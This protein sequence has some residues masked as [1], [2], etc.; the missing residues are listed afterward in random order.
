MNKLKFLPF[1][2]VVATVVVGCQ[3]TDNTQNE[4]NPLLWTYDTPFEVPPFDK[5]K[6]E[7]FRPAYE[8]ALKRQNLEIDS[9]ANNEEEASFENTII[10]LEKAG[11]LLKRVSV[12][13]NNLN[14]ANTNDTIQAIAKEMAPKLSAHR[15][16]IQLNAKLFAR[17]K[18]VYDKKGTLNLDAEDLKLLEEK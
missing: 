15:D 13:F 4:N 3:E 5:I 7:H 12:I 10:A 2:I 1:C 17:V 14:S 18:T 8:E 6:D 9:I 16:E 11:S